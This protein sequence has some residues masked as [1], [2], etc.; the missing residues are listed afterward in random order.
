MVPGNTHN[1]RMASPAA[2]ITGV[3]N[4]EPLRPIRGRRSTTCSRVGMARPL[5]NSTT[6]MITNGMASEYPG[7]VTYSNV[8]EE[9]TPMTMPPAVA[10]P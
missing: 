5:T 9:T 2:R 1:I 3:A 7:V 6:I 4:E 10:S 8:M